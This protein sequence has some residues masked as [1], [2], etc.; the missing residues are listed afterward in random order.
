MSEFKKKDNFEIIVGGQ[1]VKVEYDE[2]SYGIVIH[3]SFYGKNISR[4]GYRSYF[5][6]TEDFV[7]MKYTDY[8]ICAQDI[9]DKLYEDFKKERIKN[10]IITEQLELF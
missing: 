9:A 2:I 10:G 5:L 4:T 3:F 6:S 7:S 1:A 8:K